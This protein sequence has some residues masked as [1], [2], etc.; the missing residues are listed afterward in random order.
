VF[1]ASTASI[2]PDSFISG[3]LYDAMV[4]SCVYLIFVSGAWC[5]YCI[6]GCC[7]GF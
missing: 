6:R 2:S 1:A 5:I 4:W 7:G 3:P